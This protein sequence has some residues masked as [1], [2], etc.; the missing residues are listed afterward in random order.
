MG[1]TSEMILELLDA[2]RSERHFLY[3]AGQLYEWLDGIYIPLEDHQLE[4][5][6]EQVANRRG[7]ESLRTHVKREIA[8]HIKSDSFMSTADMQSYDK[9]H[10]LAFKNGFVNLLQLKEAGKVELSKFDF[11]AGE[12]ICKPL[13]FQQIPHNLNIE[14]LAEVQSLGYNEPEVILSFYSPKIH[15]FLEDLIGKD[16]ILLQLT[17]MGYCFL[18]ANPFKLMFM[19][20]GAQDRGKTTYMKLLL[21][22]IGYRNVNLAPLQDLANDPFAKANLEHKL[23]NACDDLPP[24]MIKNMGIIKQLSGES[25]I[26]SN[27]KFVQETHG[28]VNYSK[29]M[30]AGNKLPELDDIED[31]AFF[32]RWIITDYKNKFPRNEGFF[33]NLIADE[34]EIEGLIIASLYALRDLLNG[35]SVFRTDTKSYVEMWKRQINTVYDFIKTI[36]ETGGYALGPSETIDKDDFYNS[37]SEFMEGR[38]GTVESKTKFT[39]E[40][41][42]LFKITA[43]RSSDRKTHIYRGIGTKSS[44][45]HIDDADDV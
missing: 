16:R 1:E 10:L 8:E 30:F 4:S 20:L 23:V 3:S 15:Q 34:K 21:H 13:F 17:K 41:Q 29:L 9:K 39:Q 43:T 25:P 32:S 11:A 6:I 44:Q 24:S 22:V 19:E 28:F 27:R 2:L 42:R 33:D 18:R 31:E 14:M 45:T 5:Y 40:C 35:G 7:M 36:T 12:R 37:Y 26:N 38:I